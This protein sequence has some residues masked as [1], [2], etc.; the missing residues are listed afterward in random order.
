[1]KIGDGYDDINSNYE[2]YM[3]DVIRGSL[4][5]SIFNEPREYILNTRNQNSNIFK[6]IDELDKIEI[7]EKTI[8]EFSTISIYEYFNSSYEGKKHK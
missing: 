7:N 6:L 2:E 1:M 8:D 3:D 4:L 5:K